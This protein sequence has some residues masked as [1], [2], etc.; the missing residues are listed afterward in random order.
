VADAYLA[1]TWGIRLDFRA[2]I[3]QVVPPLRMP[4]PVRLVRARSGIGARTR[5][6]CSEAPARIV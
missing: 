1:G 5:F 2:D 3:F 6:A 4:R